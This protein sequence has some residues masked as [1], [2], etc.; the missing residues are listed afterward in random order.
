MNKVEILLTFKRLKSAVRLAQRWYRYD[1]FFSFE[2]EV[3]ALASIHYTSDVG[4]TGRIV[5]KNG[6]YI[7][8]YSFISVGEG[9]SLTIGENTTIHSYGIVNGDIYIGR[10]VLVGPRVTILSGT[11]IIDGPGSIRQNDALYFKTHGRYPCRS[12]VIG[13]DCWLGA[14][15]VIMPGVRLGRGCVVGANAVVTKSYENYSVIT[16]IPGRKSRL[17]KRDLAD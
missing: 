10:D 5:L 15:A 3:S 17:R 16:G 2:S 13:D 11:H 8:P 9:Q 1:R 6:A 7:G 4:G 14:N 12:V